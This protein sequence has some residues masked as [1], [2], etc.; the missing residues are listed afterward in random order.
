VQISA[1]DHLIAGSEAC[2]Q[3]RLITARGAID[4]EKTP[5]GT[6]SLGSQVLG[7]SQAPVVIRRVQPDVGGAELH[8]KEVT[9]VSIESRP[10]LVTW[11]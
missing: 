9:Q 4:E 10:P 6:P 1:D 3:K 8:A 5:L 2:Q 11:G 7:L